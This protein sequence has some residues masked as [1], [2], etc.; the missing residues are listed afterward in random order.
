MLDGPLRALDRIGAGHAIQRIR[1]ENQQREIHGTGEK[2]RPDHVDFAAVKQLPD[3]RLLLPRR[4]M[5]VDERGMQVDGVWHDRGAQHGRGHQHGVGAFEP[6]NQAVQ[7]V[8]RIR[9]GDEQ[10]RDEAECD[11][12]QQTDDELFEH[13]VRGALL[14]NQQHRGNRA[15]D[16]AAD[17]QGQAEQQFQCDRAADHLRQIGGDGDHLRLH[18]EHEPAGVAQPLAQ[19]L[20]QAF[21]GDDAELRGLVLDEHAHAVGQHQHPHQQVAVACAGRDVRRHIA[22]IHVGDGGHERG[23]ENAGERVAVVVGGLVWLVLLV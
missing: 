13:A 23:A 5:V 16:A 14:E 20:R 11:H 17:E 10:A 21:A 9:R 2:Q 1:G 22:R 4:V 6:R 12:Q 3:A 8:L 19:N 18:E 15:D 7:H